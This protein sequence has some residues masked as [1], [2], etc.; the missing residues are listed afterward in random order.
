M[1]KDKFLYLLSK[2]KSGE[3]SLGEVRQLSEIIRADEDLALLSKSMDELFGSAADY[4]QAIP[5]KS[6]N[7]AL[8]LLHAQ[9]DNAKE[10][11]ATPRAQ[12][13]YFKIGITVAST[14][15]IVIISAVFFFYKKQSDGVHLVNEVATNKGSTTSIVLPDGTK[16]WLNADTKLT[17]GKEF[18]VDMR[19]VTLSG[20]AFFDV[21]EDKTRPFI[22]H[23]SAMDIKVLGTAFNVRAYSN[24]ANTQT[25]LLKGSVEVLLNQEKNKTIKLSPNEKI[26]VRNKTDKVVS[27]KTPSPE[28][29]LLKI[30]A[31]AQDS[32]PGNVQWVQNKLVFEQERLENIFS[33]LER[34]FNVSIEQKTKPTN[35]NR[36]YCGTFENDSLEDVL[37]SLKTAGGFN[38]KIEKDKVV[39]Y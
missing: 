19:R 32:L 30:V 9:I 22:V 23:T 27:E 28:I 1:E 25:T 13:R 36:L 34:W 26:I 38:Y 21:A 18:G 39:I 2:K 12:Y 15:L 35:P 17:Y 11:Q 6:V 8:G 3:I 5:A 14:V 16:V 20:E 24:G 31:D 10:E 7:E 4:G 37:Q 29:Q 33:E